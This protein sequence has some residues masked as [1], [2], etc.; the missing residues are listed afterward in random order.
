MLSVLCY[1]ASEVL[2][3]VKN[4]LLYPIM[5]AKEADLVLVLTTYQ[6]LAKLILM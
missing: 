2:N 4:I 5:Y 1:S 3:M 6:V